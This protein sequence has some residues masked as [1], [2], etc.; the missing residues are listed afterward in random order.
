[1]NGRV[2][3]FPSLCVYNYRRIT[4]LGALIYIYN[5][6]S[7][8]SNYYSQRLCEGVLRECNSKIQT[9]QYNPRY[10]CGRKTCQNQLM[11]KSQMIC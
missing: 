7:I 11:Y 5:C 4:Y 3:A 6:S 2:I 8:L 9:N 10:S 1:M